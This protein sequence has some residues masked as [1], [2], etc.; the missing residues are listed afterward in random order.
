ME[1]RHSSKIHKK[2]PRE[3][4]LE[5]LI[6]IEKTGEFS[7]NRIDRILK[8]YSLLDQ[9]D[10]SFITQIVQGVIR[11]KLRLDWVIEQISTVPLKK[12][13]LAVLNILRIAIYQILFLDRTPDSAAVNE[14]VNIAKKTQPPHISSFVNAILRN[15]CRKKKSLPY[16]DR[17]KEPEKYLSILYSYPIWLVQKW[18]KEIGPVETEELLKAGNTFPKLHLRTNTLK[19]KRDELIKRLGEKGIIS[20]TVD[21]PPECITVEES[22]GNLAE[23]DLFKEGYFQIQERASQ[24]I[25]HLLSPHPMDMILDICSGAG[26]KSTHMLQL[27]NNNGKVIACDINH[28]KLIGLIDNT[29]RLGIKSILPIRYDAIKGLNRVFHKIGFNKI[30][31][32]APCSGLGT[33]S[34][35][36]D[37]KWS[38]SPA[39]IH[40]L[41]LMQKSLLNEASLLLNRGGLLLYVTCTISKEENE[42]VIKDFLHNHPGFS[43]IDLKETGPP[44]CHDLIDENGFLRTYPH[45]HGMDGFFGALI[46]RES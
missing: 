10:R 40:R 36:P 39:D 46:K 37:L 20:K 16:P 42:G 11:W 25:A 1:S 24:I 9:R 12:I 2:N 34:R 18:I 27:M 28:G 22:R 23:T 5:A 19:I 32:D 29:K 21:F 4:A 33:I 38:K 15:I 26:I 43:V 35:H 8:K 17:I 13:N 31:L 44:W 7:S 45:I 41:S 14:A 3:I 6:K 30:L